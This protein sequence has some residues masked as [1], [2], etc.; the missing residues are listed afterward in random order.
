MKMM[1]DVCLSQANEV[2]VVDGEVATILTQSR[3][4]ENFTFQPPGAPCEPCGVQPKVSG[5]FL[6]TLS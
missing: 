3:F 6:I 5:Q 1:P 4:S 2:V